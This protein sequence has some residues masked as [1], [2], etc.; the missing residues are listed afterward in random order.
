MKCKNCNKKIPSESKFCR[1][2]GEKQSSN[3]I[4]LKNSEKHALEKRY[5]DT[6]NSSIA[7]CIFGFV[8]SIAVSLADY[9][10]EDIVIGAIIFIPFYAPFYYYGQKLKNKG[11]DD[12]HYA[13]K[14]SK[15]MLIYTVI[16]V[17]V[18]MLLGGIG[19]L[20]LFLLYYFYKSFR[21]TKN[22]IESKS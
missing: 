18:N 17:I 1:H 20:W 6:G 10:V 5:R 12:L 4:S 8:A 21:E 22:I 13:L 16:F 19:W 11:I 3:D 7:L 14:V 2:C 15:G 9:P